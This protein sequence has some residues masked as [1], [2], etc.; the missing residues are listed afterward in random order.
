MHLSQEVTCNAGIS[1]AQFLNK[2]CTRFRIFYVSHDSHDLKIF[3]YIARDGSSN[4]FKCNVFKSSKK[5]SYNSS[6]LCNTFVSLLISPSFPHRAHKSS[7]RLG[8]TNW[9]LF[10]NWYFRGREEA[11]WWYSLRARYQRR[12][13]TSCTC[14][15][16]PRQFTQSASSVAW[17]F[18]NL[19]YCKPINKCGLL[20]LSLLCLSSVME[21]RRTTEGW[22]GR[23][24]VRRCIPVK[25]S[26]YFRLFVGG[27]MAR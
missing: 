19:R 12:K 15:Y 1:W 22:G 4:T 13:I 6:T 17:R 8:V 5:V 9:Y 7:I 16:V 2:I 11:R 24:D 14:V 10:G 26:V 21:T 20:G 27:G 3:S 23:G 25:V 18:I